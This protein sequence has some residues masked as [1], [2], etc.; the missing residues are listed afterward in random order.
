M[1]GAG[2]TQAAQLPGTFSYPLHL[3]GPSGLH[4]GPIRAQKKPARKNAEG[5]F[6]RHL[7]P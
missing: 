2:H 6:L 3:D 5:L 1:V 4:T 7:P